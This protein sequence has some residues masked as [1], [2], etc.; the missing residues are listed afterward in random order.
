[1]NYEWDKRRNMNNHKDVPEIEEWCI[2]NIH[3]RLFVTWRVVQKRGSR[4]ARKRRRDKR[5]RNKISIHDGAEGSV[6]SEV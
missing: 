2:N 4:H 3:I 6:E 1:M 5:C